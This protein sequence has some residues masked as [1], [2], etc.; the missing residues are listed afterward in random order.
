MLNKRCDEAMPDLAV[1]AGANG[2]GMPFIAIHFPGA[3]SA[4][5]C[6]QPH[7]T[8]AGG[9]AAKGEAKRI[10]TYALPD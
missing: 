3:E 8:L 2:M 6:I 4:K 10:G 5:D 9:P 7:P 1:A